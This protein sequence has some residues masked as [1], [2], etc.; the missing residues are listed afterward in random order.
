MSSSSDDRSTMLWKIESNDLDK[1][2]HNM[3]ESSCRVFGHQSRIF[4]SCIRHNFFVT[5]GEDS[6]LNIWTLNGILLR[7]I[8][9]YHGDSIWGMDCDRNSNIIVGS[10][11]GAVTIY[12]VHSHFTENIVALDNMTK[13]RMIGLVKS[14]AI[15]ILSESG[16]FIYYSLQRKLVKVQSYEDLKVYAVME[17]SMCRSLVALAGK[18]GQILNRIVFIVMIS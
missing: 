10:G 15:V 13:P 14:G 1:Q 5:A 4:R 7:R 12:P 11:D 8:D 17:V 9:T 6:V 16:D 18:V 2:A 3:T